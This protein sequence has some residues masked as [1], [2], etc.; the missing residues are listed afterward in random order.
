MRVGKWPFAVG[1]TATVVAASTTRGERRRRWHRWSRVSGKSPYAKCDIAADVGG[2][3]YTNAD[4]DPRVV[5]S[6]D[7]PDHVV[8]VWVQDMTEWG[9]GRGVMSAWSSDGGATWHGARV[10]FTKCNSPATRYTRAAGPWVSIG[11]GGRAYT[12]ATVLDD[13]SSNGASA[14]AVSTSADG[15]HTWGAPKL[16]GVTSA[17]VF[18]ARTTIV[19]SPTVAG[20]AYLVFDR[21]TFDFPNISFS[22]LFSKTT[23]G[24]A[25]WST[26][27][28]LSAAS[29]GALVTGH[30]L[31][32]DPA[33][34]AIH[35]VWGDAAKGGRVRVKLVTSTNGGT[36]W[37]AV[38]VV[39]TM[40]TVAVT[41]PVTGEVVDLGVSP[42][43]TADP[44][45]GALYAVWP[46]ARNTGGRRDE[47]LFSRS[48]NG[49]VSWSKVARVSSL[50]KRPAFL[51]TVAV[52]ADGVVAVMYYDIRFLKAGDAAN[53]R[54]DVWLRTSADGGR[55][56]TGDKHVGG[57]FNLRAA[58]KFDDEFAVGNYEGLTTNAAKRFVPFFVQVNCATGACRSNRTDVFASVVTP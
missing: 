53:L 31:V 10:P 1:A 43:V 54:T 11:A 34:N 26:P 28:V 21:V 20:T 40:Q 12:A 25:H 6:P 33:A 46:D 37:S 52:N 22:T 9:G 58:P 23:D 24:G 7:D 18:D 5:S 56:F 30:V 35:V 29:G 15:G 8:G 4:T 3:V 32:A 48:T 19:A 27:K 51:P 36:S 47:V 14:V 13:H 42:D 17:D 41:H 44:N 50:V 49:G 55:H 45:T 39:N 38:R 57:P 16:V 2:A